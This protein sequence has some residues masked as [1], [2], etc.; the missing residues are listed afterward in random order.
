M[1]SLLYRLGHAVVGRARL[2]IALWAVVLVALGGLAAGLGGQLQDNLTIP[3]TE[4]QQ[5]L[6]TLE[7]RFPELAGTSGQVLFVAP[8]GERVQAYAEEIR[9]VIKKVEQVEHVQV[10]TDP[11]SSENRALSVSENGRDALTQVQLD[12]PLEQVDDLTVDE[13]EEATQLSGDSDLRVHLGGQIF[14][15][16]QVHVSV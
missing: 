15:N 12:I 5:G 14:T 10:A 3:G 2:V 6:D 7:Q 8:E 9:V 16:N 1:S 11:F 13:L 4:S